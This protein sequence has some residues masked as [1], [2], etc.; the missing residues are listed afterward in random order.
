M[1]E[2]MTVSCPGCS[3]AYSLSREYVHEFG[4]G[5]T[6][7]TECGNPFL[8]PEVHAF[9]PDAP[10]RDVEEAA[11]AESAPGPEPAAVL[12]YASAPAKSS[13]DEAAP[14]LHGGWSDGSLVVV[15]RGGAMPPRCVSCGEKVA[16][17]PKRI[18]LRWLPPEVRFRSYWITQFAM[19][20]KI[21]FRAYYCDRHWRRQRVFTV[22]SVLLVL[23]GFGLFG[24]ANSLHEQQK[25]TEYVVLMAA[26]GFLALVGI[27]MF[28]AVGQGLKVVSADTRFA[29]IG[30]CGPYFIRKLPTIESARSASA[31]AT[32]E[33]LS[34]VGDSQV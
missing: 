20:E 12:P 30:G 25:G 22:V 19:T 2:E 4:G 27:C 32:A 16:G 23:L 21:G 7:C 15:A 31:A 1:S 24:G 6:N 18:S 28:V 34:Q 33:Q 5:T 14:T 26:A 11:A 10:H 13:N 3:F 8:L 29:W 17:L 9:V